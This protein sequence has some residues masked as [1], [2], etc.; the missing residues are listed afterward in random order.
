MSKFDH[1]EG[2]VPYRQWGGYQTIESTKREDNLYTQNS[3]FRPMENEDKQ[4]K[5][6]I[7]ETNKQNNTNVEEIPMK[8]ININHTLLNEY[9]ISQNKGND[10]RK[11]DNISNRNN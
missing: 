11:R 6:S 7:Q 1:K 8:S 4:N 2:G 9:I 5:T 10:I 3:L